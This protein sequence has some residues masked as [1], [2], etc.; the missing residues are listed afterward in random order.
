METVLISAA[1]T[2]IAQTTPSEVYNANKHATDVTFRKNWHEMTSIRAKGKGALYHLNY[3]IAKYDQYSLSERPGVALL[4]LL[5]IRAIVVTLF[6]LNSKY[7]KYLD[8][9]VLCHPGWMD[10]DCNV[11]VIAGKYTDC[12]WEY[13]NGNVAKGDSLFDEADEKFG[14][15]RHARWCVKNARCVSNTIIHNFAGDQ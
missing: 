4:Y 14:R 1:S 3:L 6:G 9:D 5:R 11:I 10:L 13:V 12:F 2:L 8:G 7:S 15:F